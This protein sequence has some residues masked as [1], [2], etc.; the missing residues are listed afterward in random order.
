M[1]IA[2]SISVLALA[3][4]AALVRV[5]DRPLPTALVERALDHCAL[6]SPKLPAVEC[7][8]G[9]ASLLWLL[10]R[11]GEEKKLDRTPSFVRV[12]QRVLSDALLERIALAAPEP[13][14]E[15]IAAEIAAHRREFERPERLRLSRIL[16][17]TRE[18]AEKLRA[19]MPKNLTADEF[20]RLAREHSIDKATHQ[21]G[22]DL[23]F[24]APDGTT[25]IP[26]MRV[27]PA[28]YAA[29]LPLEEGAI[30]AEPIAEGNGFALLWR[31]GRLAAVPFD[32]ARAS[33]SVRAT[34]RRRAAEKSAR[35]L[36]DELQKKHVRDLHA[37]RLGQLKLPAPR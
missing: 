8:R 14:D 22:G 17:G 16:V 13:S 11:D 5:G 2:L 35:E 9:D 26:E 28:L 12:R 20:R 33:A 18:E 27:D 19:Q 34:L 7:L 15:A 32:E 3:D 31:R 6:A 21:R 37:E 30:A 4:T 25:D 29:A 36:S 23:G 1:G 24:V 10:G